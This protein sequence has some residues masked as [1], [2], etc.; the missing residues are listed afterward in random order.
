MSEPFEEDTTSSLERARARLYRVG[1]IRPSRQEGHSTARESAHGWDDT[2]PLSHMGDGRRHIHFAGVFFAIAS[3]FF[4]TSLAVAGY[5]FYFGGNTVSVNK[6]ELVVDGP[7]TV[8][9]GDTV[10]LTLTIINRNPVTIHEATIE[11]TFPEGTRSS[12]NILAPYP[13][14]T[15][16]IPSIGSGET[17]TRSLR[18]VVFGGAG[19]TLDFPISLSYGTTGSNSVFTKKS[20]YA[21]SLS[22][23]PLSVSI[24]TLSEVVSGKSFTIQ[25]AVRSNATVALENVVVAT[26]L[27]FGFSLT[28]SSLPMENNTIM[29]GTIRPGTTREITLVGALTGQDKEERTF[30]AV[31][32]T[33][34]SPNDHTPSIEYM[35]QSAT[36]AVVAPFLR[37]TLAI[38]GDSSSEVTL[39]PGASHNATISY[40][41]T[42]AISVNNASIEV[43]LSGTGID[44]NSVRTTQGFYRSSD[45]TIIFSPDADPSLKLLPP[46]SSGVN[47]FSF[48]TTPAGSSVSPSVTFSISVSGTRVGQASVAEEVTSST[49]KTAKVITSVGV[50]ASALF[51]SGPF[52]NFGPI[53]PRINQAT[54]YTVSLRAETKG[55]AVADGIVKTII[56][57]YVTYLDRTAGKGAFSYDSASHSLIWKVGD[58]GQGEIAEGFFQVS[59]APSI[60]QKGIAPHLTGPVTFSGHDRFANVSVSAS[61]KGATTATSRDPGYSSGHATVQ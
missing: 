6:I 59:F 11:V 39:L 19:Q 34:R 29:L 23:S 37:T 16:T 33:S 21:L 7:S 20:S 38:G 22:S 28:S 8:A 30:R 49:V 54:T 44:Y 12:D 14:Y 26:T 15:E 24:D 42:L 40:A 43:A 46:G 57:E 61:S 50:D 3:I 1:G 31:V 51:T 58:L 18:A 41:N 55:S 47:S 52:V 27:P 60:V 10:P 53:P 2:A 4:L 32:G 36:F 56:P 13:R 5:F 48:S 45:H 25:L 17:I 9:G 35:T